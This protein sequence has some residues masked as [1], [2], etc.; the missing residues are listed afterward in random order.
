MGLAFRRRADAATGKIA[1]AIA[2]EEVDG[3]ATMFWGRVAALALMALWVLLTLPFERS[4]IYLLAI[5]IFA[6]LGAP[7]YLLARRGI[8][9]TLATAFFLLLDASILTYILIVPPPFLY[10]LWTPQLNYRL[11]NFL[12]FGVFLASMAL[13]YSPTLVIWAG[14]TSIVAWSTGFLWV[15][16]LPDSMPTT[17]SS[18]LDSGLPPAQSLANFLNPS[19]V[20]V[21]TWYNQ[22]VFLALVT[23][24][25][26]LVVWRSR[27]LVYRRA[28]AEAERAALSR[29]F[30]P[31]IVEELSTRSPELER[32]A[33]QPV[34]VLF[35]DMVGFTTISERMTPEAMVGLLREFHGRLVQVAFA[36]GGTIDKYIGDAIMVHFGTPR[37]RPN[38]PIQALA[39]A[40]AMLDEIRAWS[41]ER[42]RRG[43]VP[44]E[45]GVGVHYGE[46]L[47]GNIGD[48]RRL[49]YTVLGD[50]VNVASRLERMTREAGV[51][52]IVS[53]DLVTAVRGCG[54]DPCVIV[55][56]LARDAE[57]T[58][59]GRQQPI[60]VWCVAAQPAT[61]L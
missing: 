36:H 55:K 43:D 22:L 8:R 37:P 40:G 46:V 47:V 6:L 51:A 60:A 17:S 56:N 58:V 3:L 9:S 1:D 10:D 14:L 12:Y 57:R 32:P 35:A 49:E 23:G 48:A 16:T 31:N 39:C 4:K 26:A 34:A 41:A 13:S 15:V 38:D 21:T 53:D 18:Q 50:T 28:A 27:R 5:V 61:M 24:I 7:S 20:S 45:I 29:Y 44:I 11:P 52:L 19:A 25:L 33:L 54:D 30:S 42:V 2:R 59:R